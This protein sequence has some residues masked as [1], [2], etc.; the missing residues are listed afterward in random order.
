MTFKLFMSEDGDAPTRKLASADEGRTNV[1]KRAGFANI[2]FAGEERVEKAARHRFQV[3][4][5][6]GDG[7]SAFHSGY[8]TRGA[9]SN[10]AKELMEDGH[11][12]VAVHD[13]DDEEETTHHM[14]KSPR[15]MD[16]EDA[17]GGKRKRTKRLGEGVFRSVLGDESNVRNFDIQETSRDGRVEPADTG[18]D[19]LGRAYVDGTYV[20]AGGLSLD[21]G[22]PVPSAGAGETYDVEAVYRPMAFSRGTED[23][24][25]GGV[26]KPYTAVGPNRGNGAA[27][28]LLSEGREPGSAPVR[29]GLNYVMNPQASGVAEPAEFVAPQ[30]ATS[31]RKRRGGLFRDVVMAPIPGSTGSPV[32]D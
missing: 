15:V 3:H 21:D 17:E 12:H 26:E 27:Y 20:R 24:Y 6:D 14:S 28:E 16:D 11:K 32:A 31:I 19:G 22:S 13:M 18:E 30:P 29:L 25:V 4:V 2:I 5:S 8:G 23:G 9:A 7:G 1:S 10:A